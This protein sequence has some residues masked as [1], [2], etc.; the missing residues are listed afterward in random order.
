MKPSNADILAKIFAKLNGD[1]PLVAAIG[2]GRIF[3][4]V[5]QDQAVP[6]LR[7]RWTA[8]KDWDTKDSDGLEGTIRVDIWTEHKGALQAAQ[9]SDLVQNVLHLGE[10]PTVSQALLT[11]LVFQDT[12][13]EPDGIT[14]HTVQQYTA[15]ITN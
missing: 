12:F 6:F 11:R 8:A 9:L 1:A 13:T 2:A 4:Y 7:V 5:P 14:N 3:N 15:I 10:I